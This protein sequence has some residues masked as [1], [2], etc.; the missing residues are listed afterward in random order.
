MN[1]VI[2][3]DFSRGNFKRRLIERRYFITKLPNGRRNM[4]R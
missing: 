3:S 4:M 2:R 1:F